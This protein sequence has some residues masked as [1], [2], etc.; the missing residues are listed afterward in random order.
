MGGLE[1][2]SSLRKLVLD[3]KIRK[4][5]VIANTGFTDLETKIIA[6]EAG[7]D[8]FLTK[9]LSFKELGQIIRKHFPKGWL[10]WL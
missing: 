3:G 10:K 8:Y 2:V 5:I 9:P 1:T 6:Y 4:S 7:M